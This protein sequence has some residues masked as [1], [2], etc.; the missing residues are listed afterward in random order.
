MARTPFLSLLTVDDGDRDALAFTWR[1][2]IRQGRRDVEWIVA[3]SEG[4]PIAGAL[5]RALI[6]AAGQYVAVLHAGERPAGANSFADLAALTDSQPDI[7]A[8]GAGAASLV[9]PTARLVYRR[10]IITGLEFP[11]ALPGGAESGFAL[12]ALAR[13]QTVLRRDEALFR[14]PRRG[15]LD[16]ARPPRQARP[17]RPRAP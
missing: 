12:A 8:M 2:L 17:R 13:A 4:G 5:N 15:L 14:V 9:G 6:E 16:I 1:S 7:I 3:E 10:E 11:A